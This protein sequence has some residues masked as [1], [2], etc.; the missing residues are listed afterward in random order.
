M[1]THCLLNIRL[2]RVIVL[3]VYVDVIV[4][5]GDDLQGKE[6]L[7]KCLVQ[8][9]KIKELGRLKYLLSIGVAHSRH[10]LDLLTRIEKLGCKP[11]ETHIEQNHK[12]CEVV[13]DTVVDRE[14]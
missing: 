6:A 1:I 3:L 7:R 8:E 14:S 2:Q 9:F 5:I 4:V 10:V 12:F 13:E 11:V